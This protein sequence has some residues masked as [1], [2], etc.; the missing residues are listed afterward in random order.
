MRLL[1][2]DIGEEGGLVTPGFALELK[3]QHSAILH[4]TVLQTERALRV[5]AEPLKVATGHVDRDQLHSDGDVVGNRQ[6][7]CGRLDSIRIGQYKR[8]GDEWGQLRRNDP[9]QG[10]EE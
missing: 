7:G 2:G 4:G 3:R 8:L 6:L 10:E 1:L 5:V 9:G